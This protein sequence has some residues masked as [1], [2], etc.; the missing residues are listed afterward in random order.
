MLADMAMHRTISAVTYKP[1]PPRAPFSQEA[2]EEVLAQQAMPRL[3]WGIDQTMLAV[4]E[5]RSQPQPNTGLT[6]RLM[7][8]SGVSSVLRVT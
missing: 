6:C 4:I 7:A 2:F 3:Y 5:A 8:F 1:A